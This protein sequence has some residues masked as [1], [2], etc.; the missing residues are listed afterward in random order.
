MGLVHGLG[1]VNRQFDYLFLSNA[2]APRE[3][4]DWARDR[5]KTVPGRNNRIWSL[6]TLPRAARRAGVS[7]V[8]GQY[9]M[10][11]LLGRLAVTTVH[12]VSF[13]VG[14]QWFKPKDRFLLQRGVPATVRKA[15]QVITVSQASRTDLEKFIPAATGKTTVTP[16]APGIGIVPMPK[17]RAS[18]LVTRLKVKPPFVLALGTRWPRK[19]MNLAVEAVSVLPVTVPHKLVLT[20]KSGWGA[21]STGA[22]CVATGYVSDEELSALFCA[23]DAFLMPSLYEGF[24]IPVLE[25]FL[26]GCPVVS[27]AGGSLPEVAGDAAVIVESY[28]A[29]D[30][31]GALQNLLT[32]SSNL[33]LYREAGF[34]R[35]ADFSWEQ[36]AKLTEEAYMR[37]LG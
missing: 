23:A 16:L 11:P 4:P 14:P 24:G 35:V 15:A 18:E 10:S 6:A 9:N 7:L 29:Q 31:A 2:E 8:H 13:F 33:Q 37:A 34:R 36:T 25:A 19:N 22:R 12:D 28:D 5:W 3:I 30:W 20:G 1:L 21:E 32:D 27:S 17:E 26:C